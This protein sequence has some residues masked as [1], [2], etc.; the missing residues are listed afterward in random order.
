M[1]LSVPASSEEC[2]AQIDLYLMM[3]TIPLPEIENVFQLLP[4]QQMAAAV[5]KATQSEFF[6]AGGPMPPVP[7]R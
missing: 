1:A 3:R 2:I 7:R 5:H 4:L 6:P